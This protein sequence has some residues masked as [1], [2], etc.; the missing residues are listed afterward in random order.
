MPS[1]RDKALKT[2]R[3]RTYVDMELKESPYF[4]NGKKRAVDFKPTLKT[5]EVHIELYKLMDEYVKLQE[6][7]DRCQ[8]TH[9]KALIVDR[10]TFLHRRITHDFW[11]FDTQRNEYDY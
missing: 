8:S 3:D 11:V 10:M 5:T 1:S 2:I 4:C 6:D 7:L 9:A